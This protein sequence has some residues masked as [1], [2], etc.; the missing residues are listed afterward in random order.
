[1][2][3][4]ACG[5]CPWDDMVTVTD[6]WLPVIVAHRVSIPRIDMNFL[7]ISET[8]QVTHEGHAVELGQMYLLAS[9]CKTSASPEGAADGP[10]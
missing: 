10:G 2:K 6:E 9:S 3:D 7:F 4:A 8:H 1:M 5:L